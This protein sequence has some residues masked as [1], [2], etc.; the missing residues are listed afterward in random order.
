MGKT[1][2]RG[3][4]NLDSL[5]FIPL[6][7]VGASGGEM[8]E[9][10]EE[11]AQRLKRPAFFIDE[12]GY[13]NEIIAAAM[14][15]EGTKLAW[16]DMRC[17]DND[18]AVDVTFTVRASIHGYR[19][20]NWEVASYNPYFG[21]DVQYLEWWD[22]EVIAIYSEKHRTILVSLAESRA[23]LL[24]PVADTWEMR[25]DLL[26]FRNDVPGLLDVVRLPD[27]ATLAPLPESMFGRTERPKAPV[28]ELV[29]AGSFV[30]A[31]RNLLFTAEPIQPETDLLLG[32]QL[33]PFWMQEPR[34]GHDYASLNRYRRAWN[35]PVLLPLYWHLHSAGPTPS[36]MEAVLGHLLEAKS[37]P[38]SE[39]MKRALR[40][41]K[42]RGSILLG[43]CAARALPGDRWDA[44]WTDW[45][46][47]NFDAEIDLFPPL[48]GD[49][50][51]QLM[52]DSERWQ[53][54]A[55]TWIDHD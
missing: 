14:A 46:L 28:G 19:V 51:N 17:K 33:Y 9:D 24:R 12:D 38:E 22:D 39:L 4:P 3:I 52:Q 10:I 48:V 53:R 1:Y 11:M 18:G 16:V 32:S 26:Y 2:Q 36:R 44:F 25:D 31:V 54:F 50:F 7:F 47:E 42:E 23:P 45:S 27:L 21:C 8:D 6:R 13:E 20:L 5:G 49:C 55:G 35:E 34:P 43:A 41:L 40:F 37:A 15:D 30:G 29:D